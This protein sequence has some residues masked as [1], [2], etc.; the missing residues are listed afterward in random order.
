MANCQ[1]SLDEAS[2]LNGTFKTI[3]PFFIKSWERKRGICWIFTGQS[4]KHLKLIVERSHFCGTDWHPEIRTN[5]VCHQ[6]KR[7]FQGLFR[8]WSF[9]NT[10]SLKQQQE[11][12]CTPCPQARPSR[13][14]SYHVS[15]RNYPCCM[16]SHQTHNEGEQWPRSLQQICS[17]LPA[18]AKD[19]QSV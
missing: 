15:H 6:D 13:A 3:L 18:N 19:F 5:L 7:Q 8:H 2:A 12:A 9:F 11:A 1:N 16:L 17:S 14:Q 10:C 4:Q